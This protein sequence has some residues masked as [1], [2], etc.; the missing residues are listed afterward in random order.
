MYYK[1]MMEIGT[2]DIKEGG[3]L[4]YFKSKYFYVALILGGFSLIFLFTGNKAGEPGI[5][6][7]ISFTIGGIAFILTGILEGLIS[8]NNIFSKVVHS[9]LTMVYLSLF[10]YLLYRAKSKKTKIE[11]IILYLVLFFLA[12]AFF[13]GYTH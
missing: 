7:L 11:L 8:N 12:F 5:I 2:K 3:R 4:N 6:Y 9:F 1:K 10:S 13:W